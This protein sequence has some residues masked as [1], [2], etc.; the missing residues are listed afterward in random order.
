MRYDPP[1]LTDSGLFVNPEAPAE[2]IGLLKDPRFQQLEAKYRPWRKF[3]HVAAE[4]GLDPDRAWLAAKFRRL[5]TRRPLTL[6]RTDGGMFTLSE[7][8]ILWEMLHR[9]DHAVGGGPAA[10]EHP[11]GVLSDAA[12]RSRFAIKSMMDEAIDSSRIEGAVTTREKAT[13]LLQSG[14]HPKTKHELMV[15]NNYRAMQSLKGWLG[16]D[17]TPGMLCEIQQ[18]LTAGTLEKPEQAG[19]FRGSHESIVIEDVRTGEIIYT[20]PPAAD[21]PKRLERLCSFVNTRH[22]GPE[23]LHPL[24]KAVILHFMVGYE[25]PFA[26]GNGRTARAVFYWHALRSGYRLFEFLVIS[27]LILEG[28]AKYPLAYLDTEHDEGDLTYFVLYHLGIIQR[29]I[30]RLHEHLAREEEAVTESLRLIESDS[31]LNLRQRLLIRHALKHPKSQC[32]VRTH[33]TSTGIT[34]V[35]ARRDLEGLADRKLFNTTREGNAVLYVPSPDLRNRVLAPR[36]KGRRT[37]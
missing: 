14:R 21:L 23:F 25:H 34:L 5:S 36:K 33:A 2:A 7:P 18:I 8:P 17:L 20:P 26:D 24:V 27:E 32:S 31:E 10:I 19:R 13:A 37:R 22:E 29:A 3:R 30:G 4:L 28:L 35:T 6:A 16:R 9:I 11:E 15:V 12:A 1:K